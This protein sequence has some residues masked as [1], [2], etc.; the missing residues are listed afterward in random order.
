MNSNQIIIK[1]ILDRWYALVANFDN[2][3]D[4]ITDEQLLKEVAPT[5]NRGIYLLGHLIAVNDDMIILLGLGEKLFP[6]YNA[7]FLESP[8]K[9]VKEI[10]SVYELRNSW[11]KSNEI[12]KQKFTSLHSDDWFQKHTAVSAEEF[13]KEPHRNKLNILLPR[14]THLAYHLGQL[15]LLKQN[16]ETMKRKNFTA[17]IKLD[18]S[19]MDAFNAAKNFRAWWSEEIEGE[20]DQLESVF[21]YRYKDIH[22]CMLKLVEMSPGKKLVYEVLKNQFSFTKDKAE[23]TGTK[24]VFDIAIEGNKTKLQ[25][26]H[27][28][29]VPEYECY[30]ICY[31]A[32]TNY[33]KKSLY[34][35]I[36]TGKGTPNPKEGDGFNA[37]IV[38]KW[39]LE[40]TP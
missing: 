38:K 5:K 36:A 27:E 7:P 32:W 24:L 30:A 4:A 3:L 23:W 15:I 26:T 34:N 40:L 8:D 9:A 29:L 11:K 21:S 14:T 31:D 25:F 37:E 1:M 22:L 28:G 10:P 13:A 12:L 2:I 20:T 33:I 18:Q 16:T 19:P 6:A 35:L 17:T 39:K